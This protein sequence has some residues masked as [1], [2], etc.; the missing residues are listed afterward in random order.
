MTA[1]GLLVGDD[2]QDVTGLGDLGQAEDDDGARRA[3]RLDALAA[4]V[5]E[6]A[7]APERLA[8]DDDVADA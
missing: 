5:L 6:R 8:D 3:G 2:A 7:D 1:S 4:V